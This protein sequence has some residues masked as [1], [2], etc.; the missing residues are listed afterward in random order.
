MT[1]DEMCSLAI[2][3]ANK[4]LGEFRS[5]YY[6]GS[7]KSVPIASIGFSKKL[8]AISMFDVSIYMIFE[9]LGPEVYVRNN[10]FYTI[11]ELEHAVDPV[12]YVKKSFYETLVKTYKALL[13]KRK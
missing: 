5:E 4:A 13:S 2:K 10:A 8:H 12:L 9:D 11:D 7:D 3:G 1:Y 6:P